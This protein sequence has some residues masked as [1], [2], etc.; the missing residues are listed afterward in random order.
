MYTIILFIYNIYIRIPTE[1][2]PLQS[3]FQWQHALAFH[4][5]F[6]GIASHASQHQIWE[7]LLGSHLI[8]QVASQRP[9]I[10]QAATGHLCTA[11][12]EEWLVPFGLQAEFELVLEV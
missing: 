7:E 10:R 4:L 11:K 3:H 12:V 9:P 8:H 5:T 2:V 6:S 1:P